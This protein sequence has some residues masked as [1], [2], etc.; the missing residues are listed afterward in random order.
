MR[1]P[2]ALRMVFRGSLDILRGCCEEAP[3]LYQRNRGDKQQANRRDKN[4]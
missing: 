3:V 2:E 4:K 1:A